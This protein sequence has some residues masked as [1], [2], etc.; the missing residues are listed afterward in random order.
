MERGIGRT[1][2][3]IERSLRGERNLCTCHDNQCEGDERRR[4]TLDHDLDYGDII[5]SAD[6]A[7]GVAREAT[8]AAQDSTNIVTKL[9][10][11]GVEIRQVWD[12][13]SVAE[14]TNL[15]ALNATIEAA[16]RVRRVK[17]LRLLQPS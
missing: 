16:Q 3:S 9:G 4:I 17:V 1:L 6:V 14:Q 5:H 12:I 13:N 2:S 15:L 10:E 11:R 7:A 8:R